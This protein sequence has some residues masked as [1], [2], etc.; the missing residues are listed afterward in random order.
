MFFRIGKCKTYCEIVSKCLTAIGVSVLNFTKALLRDCNGYVGVF[1][2]CAPLEWPLEAD[3]AGS[4]GSGCRWDAC[5]ISWAICRSTC[6][7][8]S[9]R[10]GLIR[11]DG[12]LLA[13]HNG[14]S[15]DVDSRF[16]AT[17]GRRASMRSC[18]DVLGIT[19]VHS[20]RAC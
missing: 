17:R 5:Q 1:T 14:S 7:F 11:C 2:C 9:S 3:D 8:K 10:S 19:I 20:R 12:R 15:K 6:R 4:G 13:T 18:C 16:L